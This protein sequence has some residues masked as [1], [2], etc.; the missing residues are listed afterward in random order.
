M[1]E[2]IKELA[3]EVMEIL[4]PDF[5]EDTYEKALAHELR[6]NSIPYSRQRNIEIVYRGYYLKD[7]KSDII[8]EDSLLLELKHA[9]PNKN[10]VKQ[11]QVYMHSL[12]IDD[13][14][15][16]G[17]GKDGNV[18]FQ[19]VEKPQ[20]PGFQYQVEKRKTKKS[21]FD[22]EKELVRMGQR[23]MDYLG[24]EFMF[25]EAKF[26]IYISALRVELLLAGL[27][28]RKAEIPILYK[29]LVV[30]SESIPFVIDN[31]VGILP[32]QFKKDE[33]L[34]EKADELK[35]IISASDLESVYILGFPSTEEKDVK[36]LIV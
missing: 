9:K 2:K 4:G 23:V 30:A 25:T 29:D 6:L 24:T 28:P 31:T 8:V 15:V 11:A 13:G 26:E 22:I 5:K 34:N 20:L 21:G 10:H 1:K 14:I 33:E 16:I 17:F 3:Q 27:N 18:Y 35:K 32:L 36:L 7:V 19:D 12:N